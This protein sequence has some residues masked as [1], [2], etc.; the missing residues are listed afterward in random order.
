VPKGPVPIPVPTV[1]I[2]ATPSE[3]PKP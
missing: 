2:Y 3:S 1:T